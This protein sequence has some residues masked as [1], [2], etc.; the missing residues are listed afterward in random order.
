MPWAHRKGWEGNVILESGAAEVCCLV[1]AKSEKYVLCCCW[2]PVKLWF[3]K[4]FWAHHSSPGPECCQNMGWCCPLS[5][6][7]NG[8]SATRGGFF[9]HP[10]L[11]PH[12]GPTLPIHL[13]NA[14]LACSTGPQ[15]GRRWNH[16]SNPPQSPSLSSLWA[17]SHLCGPQPQP[18]PLAVRNLPCLFTK[19]CLIAC[20]SEAAFKG[21]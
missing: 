20:L 9:H 14:S 13:V 1:L 6:T 3:V 12:P 18:C 15:E 16:C 4:Y 19:C 2:L 10:A 17:E 11:L 7:V 8:K 5:T 21:T